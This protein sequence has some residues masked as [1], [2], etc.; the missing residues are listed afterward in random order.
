MRSSIRLPRPSERD[1]TALNTILREGLGVAARFLLRKSVYGIF[2]RVISPSLYHFSNH[3]TV[4]QPFD[5]I[6]SM[7]ASVAPQNWPRMAPLAG[8]VPEASRATPT[9]S[10]I[11]EYIWGP[12]EPN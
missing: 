1:E 10:K 6:T 3:T 4:S 11:E 2:R 12:N 9:I 5:L 7:G 8:A